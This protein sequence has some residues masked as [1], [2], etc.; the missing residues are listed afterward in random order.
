[1]KRIGVARVVQGL[2]A[3][4]GITFFVLL[5]GDVSFDTLPE[6]SVGS[7]LTFI[8]T[9]LGL[10]LLNYS[11]DTASWWLVC[12]EKRPSI[13]RLMLIRL[14]T[15]AITN[16]VPG[17]AVIGEPMK[18]GFL[19]DASGMTRAEAT[20]SFL[21]SKF[22]LILGQTFYIF[23]GL[24]LS[25]SVINSVSREAFDVDNFGLIVLGGALAILLLLLS[26]AAAMIWFQPMNS[27]F[28]FSSST[29]RMPRLW[30]RGLK[31]LRE[32]EVLVAAEFRRHRWRLLLAI[33]FS[34]ISWSLNGV[35][36]YAIASWIDL[37]ATFGQIY[38]IDAVSVV[39]RMVVFVIPIG[40]GGQDW[41][42]AGL[43]AAHGLPDPTGSAAMM[44]LLK[45]AREFTVIGVG[46]L[47]LL[48]LPGRRSNT[49]E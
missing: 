27:R 2:L 25:F 10:L 43:T 20:T 49:E 39:V 15:E 3:I 46:L 38:S 44:V 22:V 37:P 8:L 4:V 14:R 31:E 1:M 6:T 30:N 45:R 13:G 24:A 32:V 5:I 23:L 7:L 16:I 18:I 35:E 40:M 9:I 36:L 28:R 29:G 11:F 26:T 41:T 48:V 17:G 42:I 47:L 34:F 33:L 19:R 12:G 21:L